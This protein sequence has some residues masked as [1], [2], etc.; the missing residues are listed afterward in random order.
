MKKIIWTFDKE[1]DCE[2]FLKEMRTIPIK[3]GFIES[4]DE[5]EMVIKI[6]NLFEK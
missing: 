3:A 1:E 6:T 4:E 2:E 5:N